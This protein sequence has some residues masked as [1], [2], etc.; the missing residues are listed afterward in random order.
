[1]AVR[2]QLAG[3]RLF[4]PLEHIPLSLDRLQVA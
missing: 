4:R 1:M 3:I 2:L